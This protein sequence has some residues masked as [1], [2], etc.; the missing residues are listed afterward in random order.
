MRLECG[1]VN[2]LSGCCAGARAGARAEG[3]S[4]GREV[5]GSAPDVTSMCVLW[6]LIRL[7]LLSFQCRMCIGSLVSY[8]SL[9]HFWRIGDA[10]PFS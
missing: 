10:Q 7:T 9:S 3:G 6:R 4:K 5:G 2:I 8:N 1:A